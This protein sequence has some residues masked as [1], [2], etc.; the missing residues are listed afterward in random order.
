MTVSAV[1]LAS[2]IVYVTFFVNLLLC[3]LNVRWVRRQV[4]FVSLLII[5]SLKLVRH[6]E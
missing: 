3:Q 5:M 2:K 4:R 1:G 6:L